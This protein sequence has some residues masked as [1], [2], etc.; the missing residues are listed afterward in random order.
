MVPKL[1]LLEPFAQRQTLNGF[2]SDQS[3][4][5][6]S[7]LSQIQKRTGIGRGGHELMLQRNVI[8]ISMMVGLRTMSYV[9]LQ[10]LEYLQQELKLL[11][12]SL[13]GLCLM[14]N[15]D[16]FDPLL[17]LLGEL[18]KC[19]LGSYQ[20]ILDPNWFT[21]CLMYLEDYPANVRHAP[22]RPQSPEV[23]VRGRSSFDTNTSSHALQSFNDHIFPSLQ[24]LHNVAVESPVNRTAFA[25]AWITFFVGCLCL[26]LPDRIYDPAKR[27]IVLQYR[28]KLKKQRLQNKMD[29]VGIFD[30]AQAAGNSSLRYQQAKR[31]L[32]DLGDVPKLGNIFRPETSR[33]GDLQGEFSSILTSVV[34]S[35]KALLDPTNLE[36]KQPVTRSEIFLL[37]QN[38]NRSISRLCSNYRPYDDL[39]RPVVGFLQGLDVGLTLSLLQDTPD[40]HKQKATTTI[41]QLTPLLGLTPSSISDFPIFKMRGSHGTTLDNRKLSLHFAS[42]ALNIDRQASHK[43]RRTMFEALHSYYDDWKRQLHSDIDKHNAR[44]SL[45]QYRGLKEDNDAID[46]QE[47]PEWFPELEF[48]QPVE[49]T[50]G[51]EASD[52]GVIS[53]QEVAT[54]HEKL[55]IHKQKPSDMILAIIRSSSDAI[56]ALWQDTNDLAVI[57]VAR[58]VLL[59]GMILGLDQV[60]EEIAYNPVKSPTYNFYTDKNIQEG[61]KLLQLVRRIHVKFRDIYSVWPD[62]A[63][64]AEV[65]RVSNELMEF[66]FC[67]TVAKLLTKAE[68]LHAFV[69][70]W[71][72]V[73]SREYT[74]VAVYEELTALLVS[75]R[76]L[77]LSTWAGLLDSED[78]KCQSDAQSWWFL[79]Y[80]VTVAVPLEVVES[81]GDLKLH[82]HGLTK[83]LVEFLANTP[84]GQYQQRLEILARLGDFVQLLMIEHL[85]MH[86]VYTAL[87]NTLRYY[88]RFLL[89]IQETLKKGRLGLEKDVRDVIQLATWKDTNISALRESSRRSRT[90]LLKIVRKYRALLSQPVAALLS[91]GPS[92]D[93]NNLCE[94][95]PNLSPGNFPLLPKA[96]HICAENLVSW[97]RKPARFTQVHATAEQVA[98]MSMFPLTAINADAHVHTFIADLTESVRSLRNETPSEAT[99]EGISMVKHLKSRKRRLLADTLQKLRFMG[100]KSNPGLQLLERQASLHSILADS[101]SLSNL[102]FDTGYTEHCFDRSLDVLSSIRSNATSR[103]E[104][105]TSKEASRCLGNLEGILSMI[106]DQRRLLAF[107]LGNI[108]KLDGVLKSMSGLWHYD[109][110]CLQQSENSITSSQMRSRGSWLVHLIEAVCRIIQKHDQMTAADNSMLVD[111]LHQWKETFNAVITSPIHSLSLPKGLTTEHHARF[112][113]KMLQTLSAFALFIGKKEVDHPTMAFILKKLRLWATESLAS[114]TPNNHASSVELPLLD[115]RLS[116]LIDSVLA[117]IE[118]VQESLSNYPAS[119]DQ[120]CWLAQANGTIGKCLRSLR[121]EN[122][123]SSLESLLDIVQSVSDQGSPKLDVAA[124]MCTVSAP[125]FYQY[126][127]TSKD[128]VRRQL[129]IHQACCSM[130]YRLSA[131]YKQ[132]ATDGFCSPRGKAQDSDERAQKLED[133][134]GLGEG[135]G[136][137]DI[138]KDVEDDE[139][140]SELAAQKATKEDEHDEMQAQDDAIDMDHDELEG[141]VSDA[142]NDKSEDDQDASDEGE[143]AEID[144]ETGSVDDLDPSA[145]DERLWDEVGSRNKGEREN[146]KCRGEKQDEMTSKDGAGEDND[147]DSRSNPEDEEDPDASED[148]QVEHQSPEPLDPHANQEDHLDLPDEMEIDGKDKPLTDSESDSAGDLSDADQSQ[149]SPQEG[150]REVDDDEVPETS[151]AGDKDTEKL[152]IEDAEVS[153]EISED[154]GEKDVEEGQDKLIQTNGEQQGQHDAFGGETQEGPTGVDKQNELNEEQGWGTNEQVGDNKELETGEQAED[155]AQNGQHGRGE[156]QFQHNSQKMESNNIEDRLER[157]FKKLGD[158]LETWHRQNRPLESA[159]D[160]EQDRDMNVDMDPATELFEHVPDENAVSDAQALGAATDEEAHAL[161]EKAMEA[162]I[163]GDQVDFPPDD[164]TSSERNDVNDQ[165]EGIEEV[166]Q[167]NLTEQSSIIKPASAFINGYQSN[168]SNHQGS[169]VAEDESDVS[170]LDTNLSVVHLHQPS[171]SSLSRSNAEARQLWAHYEAQTH[172]LSLILTEQLRLILAPTLATRMRGDFRTGKRLNIKRIIPYIA[173]GYKRDKIWMRRS[174]PSKRSY[175]IM[176]AVDDSKSMGSGGSAAL[177]FETLALVSKSLSMLEVGQICI[178][179]FGDEVRVAHE[180]EQTFSSDAGAN[181]LQHFGFQQTRT[182]VKSLMV[183]S[184]KLF[185]EARAKALHS[186]TDLW[187]LEMII[188]DGVC[189]DHEGIRRLVRQ[190]HDERIMVVFVIVDGVKGESIMDMT[191]A[192]FEDDGGEGGS[193]VKIRRY[194]EGFPFGY[195][196]IVGDVKELPG[197]LATALRQWFTEVAESS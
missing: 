169:K 50:P 157:A 135:V 23:S 184:I 98:H 120:P 71:Q 177:A 65:L 6:A 5:G 53:P 52:L 193:K 97:V 92:D 101:P 141:E 130:L 37:R 39:S 44:T 79:A 189:E 188:S 134:T 94:F 156:G 176:F 114:P 138:S 74:A 57:P 46:P 149:T 192:E 173:S 191:R 3:A 123:A 63:T 14:S 109:F 73:A 42:L 8:P 19:V 163:S 15:A 190:A 182:N 80:E 155:S 43:L 67:E 151:Q 175:H 13:R 54:L 146:D 32:A 70:E 28:F 194:L 153:E 1:T 107:T 4:T 162:E 56:T 100:F 167:T 93:N 10:R 172:N 95:R 119:F 7:V 196:L 174:V 29:A 154:D 160:S 171:D 147:Q 88:T 51:T 24:M 148:V 47:Y 103:S 36:K 2:G 45:Y 106:L 34:N 111:A 87:T 33:L 77:E 82:T 22:H 60:S 18:H 89:G 140:L 168:Q 26:Y 143:N 91:H 145:V 12:E 66:S 180:F 117:S 187:Q 85:S 68:Q 129:L 112:E 132:I 25:Q 164:A 124:A 17:R 84:L 69:Y 48:S 118:R 137:E 75:W 165:M 96:L 127:E 121:I 38:V 59:C 152:G 27:E 64:L 55:F 116:N 183:E 115:E 62:H 144:E 72:S 150:D 181:V 49:V 9:S 76:Q 125:I 133:G 128:L 11:Q 104:D 110:E 86:L 195:Y 40:L 58:S 178:I 81:N 30:A 31:A 186:A 139:D 126:L 179:G 161:D 21:N 20:D 105:L 136:A 61:Q 16:P 102:V 108:S 197:V 99:G 41:L 122:Y 90:K 166:H 159:Q 158:A 113:N 185:R 131:I 83:S 35:A 78:R 142:S 170:A